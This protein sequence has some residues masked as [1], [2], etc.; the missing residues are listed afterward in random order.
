MSISTLLTNTLILD[1]LA[2]AIGGGGGGGTGATG[3]QGPTGP[4]GGPEGP[5]GATGDTGSTGPAGTGATGVT[6]DTGSTGPVGDTGAT[7]PAGTGATGV[8]GDTGST[9]PIGNAG[10]TGV[11]G[12]TGITGSTGPAGDVYTALAP[13][14]ITGL[15]V[16][17]PITG[18]WAA[19]TNDVVKGSSAIALAWGADSSTP[20]G[21]IVET[22]QVQICN[23][24][25]PAT[26]D[27]KSNALTLNT[28]L[29]NGV[30]T[31]TFD[32]LIT[33]LAQTV[34]TVASPMPI[35]VFES[36]ILISGAI[37]QALTIFP[38]AG[39]SY[40]ACIVS[41]GTGMTPVYIN[42]TIGAGGLFGGSL[43]TS[44]IGTD[45]FYG[46]IPSFSWLA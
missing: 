14:D 9:G 41:I 33:S 28:Y 16:S 32:T 27:Y 10:A 1:A 8:T 45:T 11:T 24:N 26:L 2:L 38:G 15:V 18:A 25:P 12:A 23:S 17:L 31:L 20:A 21:S 19:G 46:N 44:A 5:T 29:N 4:S 42:L 40:S 6:G 7:G 30:Y 35:S 36:P 22:H 13:V 3:P 43:T 39:C 37:Q 34:M